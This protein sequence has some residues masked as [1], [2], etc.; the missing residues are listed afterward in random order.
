MIDTH[1]HLSM[2]QFKDDVAEVINRAAQENVKYLHTI[3][4]KLTELA[5]ILKIA[6]SYENI[7]ASCGVHPNNVNSETIP[8]AETLIELSKHRKIISFGETGLD[9]YHQNQN[10][11]AQKE[12]FINHI[13]ASKNEKLPVIVHTRE[14]EDDTIDILISEMKEREFSGVIHCF[15]A[16]YDFA[17]KSID[18]GLY[19]S[20]AGI[21]TF[22]NALSLQEII[23]KLPLDK[24]LIETD[25]PYLAPVPHRGKRNEPAF[26][27][28]TAEFLACIFKKTRQEIEEITTNNAKK[29]FTK[30]AFA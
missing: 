1:C 20:V 3:C 12:S 19:I 23:A 2:D 24:I 17:K 22:K 29:L 14:A 30:A 9:Y 5:D 21:V 7:Y 16:S 18:N 28:Y 27:K 26:V 8:S 10:I 25:S 15:T 11:K 6:D 13:E 4:T